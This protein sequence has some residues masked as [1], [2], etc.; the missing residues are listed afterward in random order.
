M[1]QVA[2]EFNL[3]ETVFL[4]PPPST[5]APADASMPRSAKISIFTTT[6][7]LPFAGHPTIGTAAHL[8]HHTPSPPPA[9]LTNAGPIPIRR[10]PHSAAVRAQIPHNIHIHAGPANGATAVSIVKG[11]TFVLTPVPT[12]AGLGALAPNAV[13][14]RPLP[15]SLDPG[16]R[17]GLAERYFYHELGPDAAGATAVRARMFADGFED[18]ATGSAACALAACLSLRREAA[19]GAGPFRFAVTQGV[20]L[21]RESLIGVEVWRTEDGKGVRD[22]WL[23]GEVVRVMEGVIEV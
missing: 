10:A 3:S 12:L 20:E 6:Q 5:A 16:W 9:I 18:P 14:A 15:A 7:E 17:E 11:M 8:L 23:E 1:Q 22:I 4:E 19:D 13:P 2:I 21:G